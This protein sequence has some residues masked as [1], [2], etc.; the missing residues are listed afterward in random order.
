MGS[1]KIIR[2]VLVAGIV[3]LLLCV[4]PQSVYSQG[5]ASDHVGTSS[6]NFLKLGVGARAAA[7]GGA[8]V[9]I[10][11]DAT[12][13]YWNPAGLAQLSA[14]ELVFMHNDWYQDIKSE[15][16]GAAFPLSH[17]MVVG[18]GV[19]YLD[20]GAFDSYDVN[21]QPVGS[22]SAN[23]LAVSAS[24][25]LG[26]NDNLSIGVTGK[27]F[28]EKLEQSTATGYAVDAGALYRIG[29]VALGLNVTNLGDGLKRGTDAYP[30]PSSVSSGV[31]VAVFDGKV[32][33]SSDLVKPGD[34]GVSMHQG[35]EYCYENTVF[36]RTGYSHLFGQDLNDSQDGIA[37]GFGVRHSFG[38]VDYS[39]VP[40]KQTG[41]IHRLSFRVTFGG[42]H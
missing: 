9:A 28:T 32:R 2:P 30:L 37:L 15:Y 11:D 21:D 10:A 27:M 42:R 20:Y 24:G 29:V 39:Y 23:A 33:L 35:I 40:D 22:Y 18:L 1:R 6:A 25:S 17:R 38:A 31:A 14:T 3:A 4:P 12:A 41:D 7:L 26:I 13:G 19:T 34:N 36:L 5:V 16:L 8:F